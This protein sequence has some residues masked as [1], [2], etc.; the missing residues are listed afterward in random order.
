MTNNI[1]ILSVLKSFSWQ[2]DLP[3]D[4]HSAYLLAQSWWSQVCKVKP[5]DIVSYLYLLPSLFSG[6]V[7]QYFK[8]LYPLPIVLIA[9]TP[10]I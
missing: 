5:D 6:Y 1:F 8:S 4:C 10:F 3:I 7:F 9:I 2:S